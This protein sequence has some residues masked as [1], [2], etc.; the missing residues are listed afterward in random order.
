M[1]GKELM[2]NITL[3][4]K[5]ILMQAILEDGDEL[6]ADWYENQIDWNDFDSLKIVN[7]MLG[8]EDT[9]HVYIDEDSM[10]KLDFTGTYQQLVNDVTN[11]I[12]KLGV[13][14][15]TEKENITVSY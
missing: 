15:C 9:F 1:G 5:D 14:S 3:E 13:E 6:N 4:V 12:M 10:A 2:D 11:I 8:I 7:F